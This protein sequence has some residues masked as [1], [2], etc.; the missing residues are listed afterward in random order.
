MLCD[1]KELSFLIAGASVGV[2]AVNV[3]LSEIFQSTKGSREDE[4]LCWRFLM[5]DGFVLKK[6]N[7]IIAFL[8]LTEMG[9]C[10]GGG[11]NGRERRDRG[12]W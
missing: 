4:L 11:L 3:A 6:F 10:R 7:A 8:F 12:L 1:T 5:T 2:I 9:G